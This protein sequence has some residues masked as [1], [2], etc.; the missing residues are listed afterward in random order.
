M[1]CVPT[2]PVGAI[3]GKTHQNIPNLSLD[4]LWMFRI[5]KKTCFKRA[6]SR[7]TSATA[8]CC[9]LACYSPKLRNE[10]LCEERCL[11]TSTSCY[12]TMK[13][14]LKIASNCYAVPPPLYKHPQNQKSRS[15]TTWMNHSKTTRNR[16]SSSFWFLFVEECG[17]SGDPGV[18]GGL[19]DFFRSSLLQLALTF[20]SKDQSSA[21]VLLAIAIS[22]WLVPKSLC[23]KKP[24]RLIN[25]FVATS[26]Q[27]LNQPGYVRLRARTFV[28]QRETLQTSSRRQ[29]FEA[30]KKERLHRVVSPLYKPFF[31]CKRASETSTLGFEVFFKTN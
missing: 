16:P 4:G 12:Q 26:H 14:L 5:C 7:N 1:I 30:I 29:I 18:Y 21:A 25:H 19:G 24:P 31:L 17:H 9:E 3:D 15:A 28:L 6:W 11:Q 10:I 23:R 2:N 8:T 13:Y 20:Y 27:R 22:L